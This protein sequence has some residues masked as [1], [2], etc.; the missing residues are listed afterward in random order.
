MNRVPFPRPPRILAAPTVAVT[1][2]LGVACGSEPP[3]LEVG[4]VAFSQE[5]LL[6]ISPTRRELL[7]SLTLFGAATAAGELEAVADPVAARA[8]VEDLARVLRAEEILAEAEV[9][10]AV[11]AERYRTN[12]SFE[13]TVR[14]LVIL[15]E[16]YESD[17]ARAAARDRAAQALGRVRAGEPFPQVAGEVSEEPGA[18][19]RGGLL[20]P[21]REGTWVDEFWSAASAL[22]VGEVSPVVESPFGFHVLRLDG[23]DTIPFSE[24]R[25]RVAAEVGGMIGTLPSSVDDL[26]LPEGLESAPAGTDAVARFDGGSVSAAE[27]RAWAATLPPDRW[28]AFEG[29]DEAALEEALHRAARAASVRARATAAGI[30]PDP[31][32]SASAREAWVRQA[33]GWGAVLGFTPGLEGEALREVAL[34]ALGRSGQLPELARQD[35]HGARALLELNRP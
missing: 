25:R 17:E 29:G 2:L 21:G 28:D 18:A 31:T 32:V 10:D 11:L 4:G 3:A 5:D 23:R 20:E 35:I 6:G 15:S 27:L 30:T 33:Q 34:E 13:L 16:R 14:H 22:E 24:E 19:R 9:D 8:E 26:P 12:P 1:L 7:S